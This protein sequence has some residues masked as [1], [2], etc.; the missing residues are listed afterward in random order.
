MGD[1]NLQVATVVHDAVSY[2]NDYATLIGK[3][4][5]DPAPRIEVAREFISGL[6]DLLEENSSLMS[7]LYE[8]YQHLYDSVESLEHKYLSKK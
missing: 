7:K 4:L 1:N 3:L 6:K 5:D 8:T 2:A